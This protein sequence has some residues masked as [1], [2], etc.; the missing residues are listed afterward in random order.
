MT[1]KHFFMKWDSKLVPQPN[2]KPL[3]EVITDFV[4]ICKEG[5][6]VEVILRKHSEN[7]TNKTNAY[8][9]WMF[10]Q[11]AD[12]TG[13]D[14]ETIKS[15]MKYQFLKAIDDAGMEYILDTRNLTQVEADEFIKEVRKFWFDFI[16]LD[17][18]KPEEM[19]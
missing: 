18:P 8:M 7:R 15:A 2:Q 3:R 13:Q 17:I 6:L 4:N 14:R 1:K 16:G 11:I 19:D 10:G 9:H 12:Y 5:Q